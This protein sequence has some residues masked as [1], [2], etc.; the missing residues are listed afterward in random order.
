MLGLRE[1]GMTLPP[2]LELLVC[3]GHDIWVNRPDNCFAVEPRLGTGVISV[4]P[5]T[6]GYR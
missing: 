2:G 4:T 3:L 6:Q 1:S 5:V